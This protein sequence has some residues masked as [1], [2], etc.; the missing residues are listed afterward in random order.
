MGSKVVRITIPKEIDNYGIDILSG[1]IKTEKSSFPEYE[2]VLMQGRFEGFSPDLSIFKVEDMPLGQ[3][4]TELTYP[5]RIAFDFHTNTI[6]IYDPSTANCVIWLENPEIYPYWAKGTPFRL[7]LSWIADSFDA[8][9]L[10]GALIAHEGE[11]FV[12]T[13][14]SGAGKST[15]AFAA[16]SA[17]FSLLSDDYF[18]YEGNRMFP[19]YTRAK[20]HDSSIALLG[21]DFGK[22]NLNPNVEGQKRIIDL[23]TNA[24]KKFK[25]GVKV[26]HFAIPFFDETPGYQRTSTGMILRH[27]APYSLCGILGGTQRSL[28]RIKRA[29]SDESGWILNLGTNLED[30]IQSIRSILEAH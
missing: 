11:G 17:G 7:G 30:N 6:V 20:L 22:A 8:E 21:K 2:L 15:T 19:V 26:N 24:L 14:R 25:S 4:R 23:N 12:L 10:H 13:G 29:I 27:L 5:T 1:L 28:L 9:F 16:E 3:V 18:L